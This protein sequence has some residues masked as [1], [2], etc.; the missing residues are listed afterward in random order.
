MSKLASRKFWVVLV[1]FG[2]MYLKP[3]IGGQLVT[4]AIAYIGGNTAIRV[5][6]KDKKDE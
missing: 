5:M 6:T 4:L 3:E 2:L 1:A